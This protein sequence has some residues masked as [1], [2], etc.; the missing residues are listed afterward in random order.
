MLHKRK[1][2]A[3]SHLRLDL[4][5]QVIILI[6]PRQPPTILI[7][8]SKNINSKLSPAFPLSVPCR[9][10]QTNFHAERESL[11]KFA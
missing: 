3:N 9:R 8:N 10:C 6:L 1:P 11:D 2:V 7:E 4:D 5:G